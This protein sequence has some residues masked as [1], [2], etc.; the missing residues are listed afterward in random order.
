MCYKYIKTT[1]SLTKSARVVENYNNKLRIDWI[2]TIRHA[3]SMETNHCVVIL[4]DLFSAELIL[5]MSSRNT[6]R[7]HKLPVSVCY[8]K[9]RS[10]SMSSFIIDFKPIVLRAVCCVQ[11]T[12]Q[13]TYQ[14]VNHSMNYIPAN[15]QVKKLEVTGPNKQDT[16]LDY[17]RQSDIVIDITKSTPT[18][19]QLR[20]AYNSSFSHGLEYNGYS[21][22]WQGPTNKRHSGLVVVFNTT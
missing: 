10:W 7:K 14:K 3:F 22:T 16:Q 17:C 15:L 6:K 1:I 12:I 8:Q 5:P 11:V 9:L 2:L 19:Y 4:L 21:H 13:L 18:E 20:S